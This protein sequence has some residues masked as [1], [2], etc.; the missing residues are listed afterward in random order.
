MNIPTATR[1]RVFSESV[2]AVN[3]RHG[4][5]IDPNEAWDAFK[6]LLGFSGRNDMF[7]VIEQIYTDP[8]VAAQ[9]NANT[10]GGDGRKHIL[11]EMLEG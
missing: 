11:R 4:L 6:G 2:Q 1:K 7:H 9:I 5:N 8:Q 3:A 10:A